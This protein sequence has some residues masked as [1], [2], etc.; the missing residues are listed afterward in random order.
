MLQYDPS[1]RMSAKDIL[2]D[3]YFK[4]VSLVKATQLDEVMRKK[5]EHLRK[6]RIM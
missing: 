3:P 4:N 1:K 5:E 6:I 2:I